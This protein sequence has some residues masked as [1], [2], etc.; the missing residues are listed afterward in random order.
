M[1]GVQLPLGIPL[2]EEGS[3]AP[4]DLVGGVHA[5]CR[6]WGEGGQGWGSHG[7]AL[8][9]MRG[10]GRASWAAQWRGEGGCVFPGGSG[11]GGSGECGGGSMGGAST[12]LA[13]E[14]Q[15]ALAER[16]FSMVRSGMDGID[17]RLDGLYK[18]WHMGYGDADA[19]EECEEVKKFCRPCLEKCGS[20]CGVLYHLLQQPSLISTH[21][22]AS[23]MT[24]SLAALDD[25]TSLGQG[26][27]I[28]GEPGGMFLANVPVLRDIWHQVCLG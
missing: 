25:A 9:M 6:E 20:K 5:F 12:V 24:P 23:G 13:G 27:W 10:K 14:Q 11:H 2:V 3:C 17:H 4:A 8:D 21:E 7:I 26:E 19:I 1:S 28:H 15:V 18:S 16:E 22:S